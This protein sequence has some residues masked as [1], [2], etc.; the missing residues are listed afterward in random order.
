MKFLEKKSDTKLLEKGLKNKWRWE[1]QEE[2][3]VQGLKFGEWLRKIE[4][5]GMAFCDVCGKTI[6]YK[7][8]GKKAFRVHA[9]D[10]K[11]KANHRTVKSNQ[12]LPGSSKAK[13]ETESMQN[14]VAKQRAITA[15]FISEHCLPFTIAEDLINFAKR[16]SQDKPALDKTTLSKS[17]ATYITTHGVAKSFK[18]ELKQKL[19]GQ[20]LSLNIDEAT[21]NNND[22]ILNVIVQYYDDEEKQVA[23]RHLGSRKQ[24][25]ATA[26]NIM[27]SLESVLEEYEIKWSQI[28]SL[29]MD[30]CSTMRGI[31]GGVEALARE[32]NPHLLDVSGD[33]VH[34][35]NNVAKTLLSNVD[36]GIQ[37]FCSDLYYDIEESPK[38]RQL[39]HEL[40]SLMNATTP[41]HLVRPISS[42]FLQMLDVATRVIDLQDY[43]IVYYYSF[44]TEEEKT[45]Y[46]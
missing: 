23:L 8:S 18:D 22:K 35:M 27:E 19:R 26:V 31:R 12:V 2:R 38:V 39:F 5:P 17:S 34:M 37:A 16:L 46:S 25:L 1:W 7:S 11:H 45:Q 30:N 10:A 13:P 20:M 41:K 43:L 6:N 4:V 40:Q 28:V 21:N 9:D 24:N 44:L 42:R 33:T 29:L 3:D 32:K 15:A 36:E 14:R